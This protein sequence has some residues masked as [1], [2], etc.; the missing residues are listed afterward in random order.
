MENLELNNQRIEEQ[1]N[2][3]ISRIKTKFQE[4]LAE[5]CPYPQKLVEARL[6][7]ENSNLKVSQL[8]TELKATVSA[9]CKIRCELKTLREEPDDSVAKKYQKLLCEVEMMKKKYCD[10]KST[11]ECLEEKLLAMRG[12]LEELRKDSTKII[13][14]TKCCSDKNRKILHE[15]INCL[16]IDL[17]QSRAAATLSLTDKE[18]K[19]KSL[20]HELNSLC[21]CF[22]DAQSQIQQ[23]KNHVSYLTNQKHKIRPEDL[24]KIDYCLN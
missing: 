3:E 20:Q 22:N 9:L 13:S 23:L 8:Q 21:S 4:K 1:V 14:T 24:N 12:E 7:L 17:A 10:I 11:K 19:I 5:L 15:H 16:E 18:H 6:D 2:D